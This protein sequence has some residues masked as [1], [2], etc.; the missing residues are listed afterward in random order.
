M[1][2]TR[3]RRQLHGAPKVLDGFI[4]LALRDKHDRQIVVSL[5]ELRVAR[6]RL[7]KMS[8]SVGHLALQLK[9][10][11]EI[12]MRRRKARLEAKCCFQMLDGLFGFLSFQEP[13]P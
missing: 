5:G 2:L 1:G 11:A 10:A 8:D 6:D 13:R 7:S 3:A 12:G 4:E 9:R